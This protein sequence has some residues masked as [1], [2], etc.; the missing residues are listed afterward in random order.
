MDWCTHGE[1]QINAS[2]SMHWSNCGSTNGF[3]NRRWGNGM[4]QPYKTVG[5]I[6]F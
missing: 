4:D 6:G 1:V 5:D 3:P 2:H